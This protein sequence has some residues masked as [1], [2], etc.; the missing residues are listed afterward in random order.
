[1]R[2]S[3]LGSISDH[4]LYYA[5]KAVPKGLRTIAM[6]R[7]HQTE[8]LRHFHKDTTPQWN[9]LG[10]SNAGVIEY[11][12][13]C[14]IITNRRWRTTAILEIHKQVYLSHLLADLHQIWCA[15]S[16]WLYKAML[17]PKIAFVKN[18]I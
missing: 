18:P 3:S 4:A 14:W 9:F 12:N 17:G 8:S 15:A 5:P 11:I 7:S 13:Q 10:L 2:T 16:Y 1:V 6:S